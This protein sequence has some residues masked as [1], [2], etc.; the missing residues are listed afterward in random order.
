MFI[1]TSKNL[2]YL[3]AVLHI[4]SLGSTRYTELYFV[5]PLV[6]KNIDEKQDEHR[7]YGYPK[8]RIIDNRPNPA[9][10]TCSKSPMEILEKG[11]KYVQGSE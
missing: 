9:K 1:T 5:Y 6:L 2:Y 3:N 7:K 8:V 11:V 4:V 10:F